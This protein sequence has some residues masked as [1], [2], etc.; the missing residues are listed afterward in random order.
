MGKDKAESSAQRAIVPGDKRQLQR[1]PDESESAHA[2]RIAYCRL[3]PGKRSIAA[4]Y[5]SV[6]GKPLDDDTKSPGYFGA[7]AKR[8]HWKEYAAAWDALQQGLTAQPENEQ[9]TAARKETIKQAEEL[10]ALIQQEI[11]RLKGTERRPRLWPASAG[12][13]RT[14]DL[15]NLASALRDASAARLAALGGIDPDYE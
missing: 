2:G 7:W 15:A 13:D 12:A 8:F 1:R 4:A 6:K 9:L 14:A 10:Q 3:P 11:E 5:R